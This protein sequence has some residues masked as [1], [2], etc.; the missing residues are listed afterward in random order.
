MWHPRRYGL[1]PPLEGGLVLG[2]EGILATEDDHVQLAPARLPYEPYA[3][4]SLIE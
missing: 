2:G 3:D 1:V 4:G